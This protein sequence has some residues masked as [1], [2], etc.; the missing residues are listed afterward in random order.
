[1]RAAIYLRQSKDT[2]NTG[3]AVDR[4]RIDCEKLAAERG[5]TVVGTFTD[6]D[7]SASSGR[8]RPRYQDVLKLIDGKS[9]DVVIAWHVDR[10]TRRL[11]ELEDL[12]TRCEIAGVRVATVSG[13]LDLSTDAGRLVGRI[14]GAVARGEIERK[15]ARQKRAARQS[16][17]SGLAPTRRA[18]GFTHAGHDPVEAPALVELY[19]KVLGGM[20]MLAAT[21]W[22]NDHGHRT[23]TG[24]EWERSAVKKMLCNPRNSGIRQ[25]A[26]EIVGPG[27]WEPIVPEE[28]WRATVEQLNDPARRRP[29]ANARKWLGGGLFRCYCGSAVKVNYSHSGTRIYMCKAKAHMNRSADKVDQVVEKAITGLLLDPHLVERVTPTSTDTTELREEAKLLRL[30]L[31]QIEDDYADADG[32][33]SFAMFERVSAKVADKLAVVNGKLADAGSGSI[34]GTILTTRD[35]G[36]AWVGAD[37]ATRQAV[38]DAIAT[39][40]IMPASSGRTFDETAIRVEPRLTATK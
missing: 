39:V 5:W 23:T 29:G 33:M 6:N 22:L 16:A 19:D 40:T 37:L 32:R 31:Q 36:A 21:R 9:V 11:S 34:L 30:K 28:V 25:Y 35:P 14:L 26:G 15:S 4:Q 27:K 18:F 17:E 2:E 24:K 10:L 3:L 12:I 13:D 7:V 20:N 38:I 8:V 1:M